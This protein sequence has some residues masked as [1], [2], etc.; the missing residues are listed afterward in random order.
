[1]WKLKEEYHVEISYSFIAVK[2]IKEIV[3]VHMA[4][5]GVRILKPHPPRV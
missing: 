2:N 3:D 1:M 4:S 5:K